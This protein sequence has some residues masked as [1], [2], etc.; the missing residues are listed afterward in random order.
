MY[1]FRVAMVPGLDRWV[2]AIVVFCVLVTSCAANQPDASPAAPT[3]LAANVSETKV[4][5][6]ATT[7]VAESVVGIAVPPTTTLAPMPSQPLALTTAAFLGSTTLLDLSADPER[8]GD[9][10]EVGAWGGEHRIEGNV[11]AGYWSWTDTSADECIYIAVM[12]TSVLDSS[13]QHSPVS[14]NEVD[15]LIW[16]DAR[17]PVVLVYGEAIVGHAAVDDTAEIVS[18]VTPPQCFLE[19]V[20]T[21]AN[22][23]DFYLCRHSVN[24]SV[25]RPDGRWTGVE[26]SAEQPVCAYATKGG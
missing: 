3:G 14:R 20:S 6:P 13:G 23:G 9:G 7:N 5:T 21:F 22:P 16:L 26:S 10:R 17:Q 11:P 18:G 2:A 1:S 15:R 4:P 24:G 19:L 25:R 8:D 12:P